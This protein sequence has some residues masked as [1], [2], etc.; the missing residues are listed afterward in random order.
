M[1]DR[2]TLLPQAGEGF[3]SRRYGMINQH[4]SALGD[5]V[6]CTAY[7]AGKGLPLFIQPADP[8][9]RDDFDSALGW[10]H[11]NRV[12]FDALLLDVGALLFRGFPVRDTASFAALM[13]HHARP[14]FGYTGGSSPR[15]EVAPDVFESTRLPAVERIWLHQEMSYLPT[16]PAG[17]AFYCRVAPVADGETSLGDMRRITGA[18]DPAFVRSVE[19]RG[20][21]YKRNF[22]DR[23][24]STGHALLDARH[25]IWQD[26]FNTEDRARPIADC[27]AIGLEAEWLPDGSLSTSYRSPGMITHPQT[28][29]RLWFNQI[30]GNTFCPENIGPELFAIYEDH[31]GDKP[32]P[33]ETS[34][35]DGG[36]IPAGHLSSLYKVLTDHEIKFAWSYG[37]FMLIDNYRT[38]HGRSTYVGQR[39]IHAALLS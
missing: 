29:D 3:K 30:A 26:A 11:S 2:L 6:V 15:Q 16:Y 32:R 36:P 13:R 7:P 12:L 4:I 34:Y 5:A 20:V 28:G 8:R 24:T 18:L 1:T 39:E 38:A 19:E 17:I 23:S 22:R 35:N 27:A 9:L 37:D 14:S 31:Y 25:R 21:M 10:F 33:Y